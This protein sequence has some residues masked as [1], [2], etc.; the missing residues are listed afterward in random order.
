LISNIFKHYRSYSEKDFGAAAKPFFK[1][2]KIK[3]IAMRL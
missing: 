3:S 2:L 1:G